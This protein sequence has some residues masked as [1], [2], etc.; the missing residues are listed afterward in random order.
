[1]PKKGDEKKDLEVKRIIKDMRKLLVVTKGSDLIDNTD[2][3]LVKELA[4]VAKF[5]AARAD[6]YAII[7]LEQATC[8]SAGNRAGGARRIKRKKDQEDLKQLES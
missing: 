8:T 7:K 6:K 4:E 1:M 5:V 2:R 3:K